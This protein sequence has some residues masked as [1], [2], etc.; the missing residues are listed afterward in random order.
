M[1]PRAA[2]ACRRWAVLALPYA[3]LALF[4]LVPFVIVFKISLAE[5]AIGIPPY[6]PLLALDQSGWHIQATS[7]NYAFLLSESL[8]AKA[9]LNALKFTAIATLICLLIGYPMAYAIARAPDAWRTRLLLL[10]ILPFWT[11]FLIRVYAWIGLL[12]GNG[13]INNALLELGLIHEPLALINNAFSVQIGLVYSYLPY[14]ILPL[15][16]SL[17]KL[18]WT[19]LEAASDLGARPLRAFLSVTLPLSLSGIAAGAL[20]VFIPMVGEFVIP[21][22]L[23]G[24][25][26]LMIGKV[27][28][29]EFFTNHDWPVAAAVAVALLALLIW[30]M[31]KIRHLLVKGAA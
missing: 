5:Q 2:S 30:P 23:G 10:V 27:L 6:T 31:G 16:A 13:F 28:W 15:Y 24:P 18:D 8:Y 12:K 19:L 7:S 1:S 11:S 21:D 20:L 29:D 22:L 25:G 26:T 14:M 3:W 17:E 4:F 9:Y